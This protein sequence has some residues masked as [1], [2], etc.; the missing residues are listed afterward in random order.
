MECRPPSG[1]CHCASYIIDNNDDNEKKTNVYGRRDD[2][3]CL[4]K[5]DAFVN[6]TKE[7]EE[8]RKSLHN[9]MRTRKI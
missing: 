3:V 9:H 4:I 1:Y 8:K 5:L 7:E 2:D 6:K